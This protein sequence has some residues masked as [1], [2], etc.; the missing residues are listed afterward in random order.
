MILM[1]HNV[2][3]QNAPD[4][5]KLQSITLTDIDFEKQIKW[6]NKHYN[7]LSLEAY[8]QKEL[9]DKKDL[10]ITFDDGTDI[11]FEYALPILKKYNTPAT[12]FVTTCQLNDDPI[13][14]GAYFN[15]LCFEKNYE[16]IQVNGHTFSLQNTKQRIQS[17][18]QLVKMAKESKNPLAFTDQLRQKYPLHKAILPYYKGMTNEQL[19]QAG[20]EPL[21]EIGGHSV[22]HPFLSSLSVEN[23][24]KELSES[25]RLLETLTEKPVRYFAYPS[26]DYNLDTIELLKELNYTAAFAVTPKQISNDSNFE[27]PRMGIFSS[28]VLKMRLKFLKHRLAS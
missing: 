26:G 5:Y 3:P 15:A 23:Q 27:V 18:S 1:Y 10:V 4:G 12:I 24:K 16:S 25:K 20:Q 17:R 6:L 22:T 19:K 21:I 8:M 2:V 28:S 9:K 7:M 13:I 14:W 11:T